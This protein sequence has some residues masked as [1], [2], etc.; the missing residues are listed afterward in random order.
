MTIINSKRIK[1]NGVI[2]LLGRPSDGFSILRTKHHSGNKSKS[3]TLSRSL[4]IG[5]PCY[6]VMFFKKELT[7]LFIDMLIKLYQC[8][9]ALFREFLLCMYFTA[10]A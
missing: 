5:L 4:L 1:I 6:D 3:I 10:V 9:H 8:I 2:Q 7:R